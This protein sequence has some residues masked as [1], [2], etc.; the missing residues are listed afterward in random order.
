MR[1]KAIEIQDVEEVTRSPRSLIPAQGP[2]NRP[3]PA[4]EKAKDVETVPVLSP[5]FPFN[6]PL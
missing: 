1:P 2:P 6:S 3:A 4:I 5:P